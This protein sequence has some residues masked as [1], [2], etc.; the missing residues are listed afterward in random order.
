MTRRPQRR[1]LV[2]QCVE[3]RFTGSLTTG[4]VMPHRAIPQRP[5]ERRRLVRLHEEH[6]GVPPSHL[7]AAPGRIVLLGSGQYTD[8]GIALAC[9][10][11]RH[12]WVAAS[13]REDRRLV[14]YS[15]WARQT[16]RFAP[17]PA[18]PTGHGFWGDYVLGMW[19]ALAAGRVK[20]RGVSLTVTGDLPPGIG[21][22]SSAALEIAVGLALRSLWDLSLEDKDLALVAHR[23]ENQFVG[24]RV[25]LVDQMVTLFARTGR[26]LVLDSNTLEVD[27]IEIPDDVTFVVCDSG[28]HRGLA[29]APLNSRMRE[30]EEGLRFFKNRYP[31]LTGFRQVSAE[32]L[33]IAAQELPPPVLARSR[34]VVTENDRARRSVI[35]LRWG[36]VEQFGG[37]ATASY[38]SARASFESSSPEL[39]EI[40]QLGK[41]VAG[42]LG[43][44][45]S[46]PGFGGCTVHIVQKGHAP[47]LAKRLR[48]GYRTPAM[49]TPVV[50]TFEPT[51]CAASA[52]S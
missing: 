39:D 9:S 12:T 20:D 38:R 2:L 42:V 30:L 25:G 32:M 21:L 34:H 6:H 17:R 3:D 33:V 49:R 35:A 23:V 50:Y 28:V 36:D 18:V 10:I 15:E 43:A 46:G 40:I 44:H 4:A 11:G 16:L 45:V 22:G 37:L 26:I 29:M 5:A 24:V 27:H 19:S 14:V 52:F 1:S 41:G 47:A 51:G 13:P 48:R 31:G 7:A 8:D